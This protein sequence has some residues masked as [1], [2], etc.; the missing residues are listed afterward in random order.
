MTEQPVEGPDD[1]NGTV[2]ESVGQQIGVNMLKLHKLHQS[3][4]G[5]RINFPQDGST[6]MSIHSA[7]YSHTENLTVAKADITRKLGIYGRHLTTLD[8]RRLC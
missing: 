7:R 6:N 2:D 1:L 3:L 4:Q 5:R 8:V